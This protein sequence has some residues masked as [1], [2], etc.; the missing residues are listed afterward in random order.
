MQRQHSKNNKVFDWV[1]EVLLTSTQYFPR[2][3][4]NHL[5]SPFLPF[6][7]ARSEDSFC[8]LCFVY[9]YFL[10]VETGDSCRQSVCSYGRHRIRHV[11]R[12]S[13]AGASRHAVGALPNSRS[14]TGIIC[15][16]FVQFEST[17]SEGER[18]RYPVKR[19]RVNSGTKSCKFENRQV[20]SLE[21]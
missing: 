12:V 19:V 1:P 11:I 10:P 8:R 14:A 3:F 9:R 5:H 15:V 13:G 4:V 16:H 7:A 21:S 17:V 20:F 6:L 18:D 2:Y